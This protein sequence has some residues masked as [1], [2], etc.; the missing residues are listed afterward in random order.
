MPAVGTKTFIVGQRGKPLT[1][2]RLAHEF[3]KWATAAGLLA[4]CRLH[5]LKKAGMRTIAEKGASTHELQSISGHKTLAMV[6]HYTD[7]VDR[8]KLADSAFEKI[9]RETA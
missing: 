1:P 3:A 2:D 5:G 6:A 9:T 8:T 7:A 4:R